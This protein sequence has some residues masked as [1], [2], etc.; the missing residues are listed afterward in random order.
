MPAYHTYIVVTI[1][2]PSFQNI[3]FC[4]FAITKTHLKEPHH[5][6]QQILHNDSEIVPN[7]ILL[8]QSESFPLLSPGF[9]GHANQDGDDNDF[10]TSIPRDTFDAITAV[11][12]PKVRKC[13][14]RTLR[15][16]KGKLGKYKKKEFYHGKNCLENS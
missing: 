5:I 7:P 4:P 15:E 13:T 16:Y 14:E 2:N 10:V 3:I 12:S 9:R 11:D 6:H 8:V 1:R